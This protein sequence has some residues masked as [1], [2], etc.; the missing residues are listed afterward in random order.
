M[1]S[2]F[3][4]EFDLDLMFLFLIEVG[5][6]IFDRFGNL[7]RRPSHFRIC[8][9][10][11]AHLMALGRPAP[12]ALHWTKVEVGNPIFDR[13]GNLVHRP[14]HNRVASAALHTS[15]RWAGQHLERCIA[16][17]V[18]H[19]VPAN[20]TLLLPRRMASSAR[21]K[22]PRAWKYAQATTVSHNYVPS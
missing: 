4:D 16:L 5:N 15:W 22:A 17:K 9:C 19:V 8:Q 12:Q 14:S 21:M 2:L 7:A 1:F 3:L 18:S 20:A 10:R 6:P 11:V 13:F